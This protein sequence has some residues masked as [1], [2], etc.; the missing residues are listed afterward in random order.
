MPRLPKPYK[1][2]GIA[3]SDGSPKKEWLTIQVRDIN[4]GDLVANIGT[5]DSVTSTNDPYRIIVQNIFDEQI[6]MNPYDTVLAF[7]V[8]LGDGHQAGEDVLRG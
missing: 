8:P 1:R 6:V 3:I 4:P 2:P 7:R 5:V